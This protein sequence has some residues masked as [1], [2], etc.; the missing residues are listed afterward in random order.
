MSRIGVIITLAYYL[1]RP[2]VKYASIL[3][4]K[5]YFHPYEIITSDVIWNVNKNTY[6]FGRNQTKYKTIRKLDEEILFEVYLRQNLSGLDVLVY[7][8]RSSQ[9]PMQIEINHVGNSYQ[10]FAPYRY[11]NL[12]QPL[13]NTLAPMVHDR[14]IWKCIKELSERVIDYIICNSLY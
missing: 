4:K 1:K 3:I 11:A 2:N 6:V 8:R 13:A 9:H 12:L 5:L 10:L 7:I 14:H